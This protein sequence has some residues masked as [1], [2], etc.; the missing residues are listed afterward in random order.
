[1]TRSSPSSLRER[2]TLPN[3][4]SCLIAM[5]SPTGTCDS[6]S[7]PGGK[8]STA[9]YAPRRRKT[10]VSSELRTTT[11]LEEPLTRRSGP[12]TKRGAAATAVSA[13]GNRRHPKRKRTRSCVAVSA[14]ICVASANSQRDGA[15][16]RRT[17]RRNAAAIEGAELQVKLQSRKSVEAFHAVQSPGATAPVTGSVRSGVAYNVRASVV[18]SRPSAS[19]GSSGQRKLESATRTTFGGPTAVASTGRTAWFEPQPP[20]TRATATQ[21][22][23]TS[24]RGRA[25]CG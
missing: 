2:A 3:A 17:T 8:A 22:A 25:R 23:A 6:P 7:S 20:A 19:A 9:A 4:G 11:R 5:T 15:S 13:Y 21:S 10:I 18:S 12:G 1:M 14:E 24:A 16:F